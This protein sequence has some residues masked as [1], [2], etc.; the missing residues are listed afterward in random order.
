MFYFLLF[1]L[2]DGADGLLKK[3][4]QPHKVAKSLENFQKI[5]LF[6]SKSRSKSQSRYDFFS[7]SISTIEFSGASGKVAIISPP[8]FGTSPEAVGA[9]STCCTSFIP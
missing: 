8:L 7:F 5:F 3:I 6:F 1:F 4:Q 2:A 9:T